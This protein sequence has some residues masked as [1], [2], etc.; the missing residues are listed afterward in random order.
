MREELIKD[1][2]AS[3][4]GRYASDVLHEAVLW[5]LL[6]RPSGGLPPRDELSEELFLHGLDKSEGVLDVVAIVFVVMDE[7]DLA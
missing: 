6:H 3:S 5:E 1:Y 4:L 2:V 7:G